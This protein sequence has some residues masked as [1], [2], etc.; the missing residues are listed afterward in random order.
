MWFTLRLYPSALPG[1]E[2]SED[3]L[4]DPELTCEIL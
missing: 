3:P 1:L 4:N 2:S